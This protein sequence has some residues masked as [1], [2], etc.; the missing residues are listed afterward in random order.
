MSDWFDPVVYREQAVAE[1]LLKP[2][3]VPHRRHFQ[4]EVDPYSYTELLR[5]PLPGVAAPQGC[6]R[7]SRS[8]TLPRVLA[9]GGA[10][11]DSLA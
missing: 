6:L 4:P 5:E 1:L 2:Q 9:A 7:F 8:Q 11:R 3:K 10:A